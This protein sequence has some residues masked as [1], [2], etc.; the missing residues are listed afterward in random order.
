MQRRLYLGIAALLLGLLNQA[1]I[2]VARAQEIDSRQLVA[3]RET[4]RLELAKAVSEGQLS[5]IDQYRI[6]LHAKE[7]LPAEDVQGLERT[8]DRLAAMNPPAPLT[9]SAPATAAAGGDRAALVSYSAPPSPE[10][11]AI[12]PQPGEPIPA[13]PSNPFQ[14]ETP[15]QNPMQTLHGDAMFTDCEAGLLGGEGSVEDNL[16]SVLHQ[17]WNNL[18]LFTAIES[19]KGPLDEFYPNGNYGVGFGLNAGIPLSY[20]WGIGVQAGV[21]TTVTHFQGNDLSSSVFGV[22]SSDVRSQL[23][24]TIG[25]FQRLPFHGKTLL[26]G[27]THDWLQDNYYEDFR[28]AQWRVKLGLE[29]DPCNEIGIWAAMPDHGESVV[30]QLSPQGAFTTFDFRPMAQG[31]LYWQHTWCSGASTTARVGVA[32]KPS[33]FVFGGDVRVPIASRL[34]LIGD[35]AYVMP[36]AGGSDGQ[37]DEIWSVT[38]GLEFVPGGAHQCMGYRF[39]PVL[40]VADN[41]SFA[42]QQLPIN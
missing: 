39:A 22:P 28:F 17:I 20:Q 42:V 9:P 3:A 19:F 1:G 16:R 33:N 27:F 29:W 21:S 6:L 40:P 38:L 14:E 34:S 11:A 5:R 7:I 15:G 41:G 35:F 26:W 18:S 23:F 24:T 30:F 12:A 10:Q 2:D 25:L 13:V 36:R 4:I 37:F 32:Q 31:N 8:M